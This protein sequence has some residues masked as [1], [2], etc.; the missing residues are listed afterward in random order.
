MTGGVEEQTNP[1]PFSEISF[2]ITEHAAITDGSSSAI[3]I[4]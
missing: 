4:L 1:L 3:G 2:P